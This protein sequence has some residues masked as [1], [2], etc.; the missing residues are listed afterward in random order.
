MK[1]IIKVWKKLVVVKIINKV[2]F[3]HIFYIKILKRIEI[4][5]MRK[6][7][8]VGKNHNYMILHRKILDK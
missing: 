2:M 1:L 6:I 7:Y 5:I 3:L 4:I 8:W